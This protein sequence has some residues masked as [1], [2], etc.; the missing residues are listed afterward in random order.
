MTTVH[1]PRPG[2]RSA[3]PGPALTIRPGADAVIAALFVLTILFFI[4]GLLG[5]SG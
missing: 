3:V 4:A 2:R 5:L 1:L